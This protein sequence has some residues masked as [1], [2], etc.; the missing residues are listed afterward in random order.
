[1]VIDNVD[2]AFVETARTC[3]RIP[4]LGHKI[5][6]SLHASDGAINV[7]HDDQIVAQLPPE[8]VRYYYDDL[9]S[10][11][12]TGHIGTCYAYVAAVGNKAAPSIGINRGKSAMFDG[13][14]L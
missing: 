14:I 13:G 10:I 4:R 9:I 2:P 3:E 12:R 7:I 5:L 1:M 8:I 11:Q 6:V